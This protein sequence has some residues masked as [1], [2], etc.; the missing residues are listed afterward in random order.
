MY[1]AAPAALGIAEFSAASPDATWSL[2][3]FN[4]YNMGFKAHF[5]VPSCILCRM[6]FNVIPTWEP[7]KF[8]VGYNFSSKVRRATLCSQSPRLPPCTSLLVRF[9]PNPA[10]PPA[11]AQEYIEAAVASNPGNKS[12]APYLYDDGLIGPVPDFGKG[13]TLAAPKPMSMH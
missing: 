5:P 9:P 1:G 12:Y 3:V 7:G 2:R 4:D 10:T 8:A 6:A 11:P 13:F